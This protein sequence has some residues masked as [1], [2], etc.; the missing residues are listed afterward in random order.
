MQGLRNN[1]NTICAWAALFV[2]AATVFWISLGTAYHQLS[3]GLLASTIT[4]M[5]LL[6]LFAGAEKVVALVIMRIGKDTHRY[7]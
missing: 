4:L 6:L 7:Q 3:I 1:G 2:S 5:I